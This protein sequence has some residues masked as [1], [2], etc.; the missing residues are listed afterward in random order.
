MLS[1]CLNLNNLTLRIPRLIGLENKLEMFSKTLLSDLRICDLRELCLIDDID[2]RSVATVKL[3]GNRKRK[4]I[5]NVKAG[6]RCDKNIKNPVGES[7]YGK[8]LPKRVV[9]ALTLT[10]SLNVVL[11]IDLFSSLVPYPCFA[12]IVICVFDVDG[13]LMLFSWVLWGCFN[14]PC[15]VVRFCWVF[16][17]FCRVILCWP[18]HGV[19][20]IRV[21]VR[22]IF[23]L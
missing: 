16:L 8:G 21:V 3:P 2:Q 13:M 23:Y 5:N 19:V 9:V 7:V 15:L 17:L 18:V 11:Y 10:V 14:W 6:G 22:F 1:Q 12:G 4:K 20:C